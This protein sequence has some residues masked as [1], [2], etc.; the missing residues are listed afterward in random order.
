MSKTIT[1]LIVINQNSNKIKHEI[2]FDDNLLSK[3]LNSQLTPNNKYDESLYNINSQ[4]LKMIASTMKLSA[5]KS[6]GAGTDKNHPKKEIMFQ[7]Y[8][9]LY[10]F[11]YEIVPTMVDGDLILIDP[12]YKV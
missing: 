7:L 4:T 3:H 8:I 10:E 9:K 11:L 6:Y 1:K 2:L 5:I 12:S